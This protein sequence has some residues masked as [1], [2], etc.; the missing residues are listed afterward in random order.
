MSALHTIEVRWFPAT[1]PFPIADYFADAHQAPERTD[2]Y[3]VPCDDG[4][5]VKLREGRLETKLRSASLG[6]FNFS[7]AITGNLETW[8]KWGVEL[9]PT[10]SP[11]DSILA[12]ANWLSVTKLR[13]VRRFAISNNQI[14]ETLERSASGC[15]F[16]LTK[17]IINGQ[18]YWTT[19]FEA[20]VQSR[21]QGQ[22]SLQRNLCT[23]FELIMAE[24]PLPAASVETSVGYPAW[25]NQTFAL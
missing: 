25:L 4:S 18:H 17:L 20:V 12:A 7:D 14:S 9:D 5:G 10:D 23:V 11:T 2:W 24:R 3:A 6:Q 8:S 16:E 15:S 1:Q 22:Q 19:G 21:E 13:Y